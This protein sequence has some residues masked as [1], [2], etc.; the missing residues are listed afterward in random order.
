MALTTHRSNF[1]LMGAR[2]VAKWIDWLRG[3]G[4]VPSEHGPIEFLVLDYA[5]RQFLASI[6]PLLSPTLLRWWW[7]DVYDHPLVWR[8]ASRH[9]E[10]DANGT[11]SSLGWFVIELAAGERFL[12]E[13]SGLIRG[14]R[15]SQPERLDLPTLVPEGFGFGGE[16]AALDRGSREYDYAMF[17]DGLALLGTPKRNPI[18]GSRV[19]SPKEGLQ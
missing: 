10:L 15:D 2:P 8:Y 11:R 6:R 12:R 19:W 16:F 17:S 5:G 9:A 14:G 18:V 3:T 7:E 13:L 4:E 1:V